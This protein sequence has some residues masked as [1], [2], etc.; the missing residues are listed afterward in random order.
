MSFPILPRAVIGSE[1]SELLR[2]IDPSPSLLLSSYT[3]QCEVCITTHA[4][5][6]PAEGMRGAAYDLSS[7]L[8]WASFS[9]E[10]RFAEPF[11][12]KN[13]SRNARGRYVRHA[14]PPRNPIEMVTSLSG[15]SKILRPAS[16][17]TVTQVGYRMFSFH[18]PDHPR[19]SSSSMHFPV[20]PRLFRSCHQPPV[21][22]LSSV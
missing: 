16:L 12:I 3:V 15:T 18:Q 19:G 17:T 14:K 4:C 21:E 1:R 8:E 11:D 7:I 22:K 10:E 13:G 9:W 5:E 6:R 20:A 2:E